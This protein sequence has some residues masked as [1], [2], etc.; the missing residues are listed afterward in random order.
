MKFIE[1]SWL[2]LVL[3]IVFA[4][5]L[6]GA[7]T[8]LAP[9][10]AVNQTRAL[11]EA[12]GQVVPNVAKTEVVEVPG[13]DRKVYRCLG[14]DGKPVGWAVDALGLGFA[15]KIRLVVG[16]TPDGAQVTG[17][18]VIENVETP[19]LGN[20]VADDPWAAQYRGLDAGRAITVQKHPPQAGA[21]E[22]QAVTGATISSKAVTAIVNQALARVRPELSRL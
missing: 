9:Q 19:G 21:N 18:K 3:G 13:Y 4:V 6:A 12:I 15:D 20:K 10:I 16:L 11:N 14:A 1:E 5:L 22:I 7:Q 8:T 17:L 2:I